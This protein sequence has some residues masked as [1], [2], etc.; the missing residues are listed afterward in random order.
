LTITASNQNKVYGNTLSLNGTDFTHVGL[1]NNDSISSASLTSLGTPSTA[2]V[3]G[4]PYTINI[5]SA[6]G[7]GLGN[8]AITYVPGALTVTPAPLTLTAINQSKVYGST[9]TFAGNE[10]SA[11]G[12]KNGEIVVS[13]NL[14]SLGAAATAGVADSPYAITIA[15]PGGT[16][17]DPSNYTIT[18][19][20]GALT[21]AQ[22]G[23]TI[24]ASNQTKVY[25]S[26]LSLTGTDFTSVGLLNN[27]SISSASL[28]VLERHRPLVS[29]AH[30]TQ[31]ILAVPSG[32]DLGTTR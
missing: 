8:Y 22:A 7:T 17:F 28:T 27:D 16:N 12:L 10:F 4:S 21:V 32:R 29:P 31:S 18:Y 5:G 24:T 9:F 26:T 11:T 20:P 19:V 6:V 15:N 23:L 13:V 2:G 1:L 14:A 3:T 30:P 25:G